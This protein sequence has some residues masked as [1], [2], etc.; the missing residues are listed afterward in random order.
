MAK[1]KKRSEEEIKKQLQELEK[2]EEN[3]VSGLGSVSDVDPTSGN[4]VSS[5]DTSAFPSYLTK[6]GN[7]KHGGPR[8]TVG[9][10]VTPV[11]WVVRSGKKK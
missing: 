8:R 3:A 5:A 10:Q 7:V 4:E 9:E 6:E 11:D 2:G 1:K